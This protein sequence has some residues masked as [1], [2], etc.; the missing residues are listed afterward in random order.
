MAI[1][2]L[3]LTPADAAMIFSKASGEKITEE[4]IRTAINAGLP[5]TETGGVNLVFV[6]AWLN[7]EIGRHGS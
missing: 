4:M 7:K 5:T 3:N 1:D 6:A 2:P